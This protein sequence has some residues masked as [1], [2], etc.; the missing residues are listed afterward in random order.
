M[1]SSAITPA[2]MKRRHVFKSL[3]R[4]EEELGTPLSLDTEY[5]VINLLLLKSR[6]M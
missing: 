5:K 3:S 2:E 6:Q 4:A 1:N